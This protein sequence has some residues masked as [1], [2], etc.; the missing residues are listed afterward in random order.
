[1]RLLLAR[2]GEALED[3]M[4]AGFQVGDRL[5]KHPE[6]EGGETLAPQDGVGRGGQLLPS[7]KVAPIAHID[8]GQEPMGSLFS[9][10]AQAFQPTERGGGGG[11]RNRAEQGQ[12]VSQGRVPREGLP[13]AIRHSQA[14]GQ[15]G[16]PGIDQGVGRSQGAQQGDELGGSGPLLQQRSGKGHALRLVMGKAD[17]GVQLA[18]ARP[19]GRSWSALSGLGVDGKGSGGRGHGSKDNA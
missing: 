18:Q 1:M 19:Q 4:Q 12:V 2:Q 7:G 17:A 3:R 5:I 14:G 10:L 16:G 11:A 9:Q 6:A 8:V 13:G 15:L